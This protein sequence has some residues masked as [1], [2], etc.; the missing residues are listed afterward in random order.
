[1]GDAIRAI[2]L[3]AALGLWLVSLVVL[4]VAVLHIVL[5]V[6]VESRTKAIAEGPEAQTTA[7][8]AAVVLDQL[9][10]VERQATTA[11]TAALVWLH[12]S[13]AQAP[14]T[15]VAVGAAHP[16]ELLEQVV[17]ASVVP[18]ALTQQRRVLEV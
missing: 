3:A 12:I 15:L 11:T 17:Q 2:L 1:M 9:V 5:L 6:A 4:V 7:A 10:L 18:V 14:P 8:A 13:P 16:E